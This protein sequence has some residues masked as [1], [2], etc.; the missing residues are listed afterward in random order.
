MMSLRMLLIVL[1]VF[2]FGSCLPV[3]SKPIENTPE[4]LAWEAWIMVPPTQNKTRKIT[5]KSIF[6]LPNKTT[7]PQIN[8]PPGHVVEN[9]KCIPTVQ[10]DKHMILL[11]NLAIL[12]NNTSQESNPDYD[13]D[14][15]DQYKLIA[16]T[17][18]NVPETS[19]HAPDDGDG[20]LKIDLLDP[21]S[22]RDDNVHINDFSSEEDEL[23]PKPFRAEAS[24]STP[25]TTTTTEVTSSNGIP[26]FVNEPAAGSTTNSSASSTTTAQPAT[27][28]PRIYTEPSTTAATTTAISNS[29]SA[30][31]SSPSTTL[32][33]GLSSTVQPSSILPS[34]F[35]AVPASSSVPLINSSPSHEDLGFS[36]NHADSGEDYSY[37]EEEQTRPTTVED[38]ESTEPV[39][40]PDYTSPDVH[41]E[42]EDESFRV[43]ATH[44]STT[45]VEEA[46]NNPAVADS[47]SN[48]EEQKT[49]SFPVSDTHSTMTSLYSVT[50]PITTLTPVLPTKSTFFPS[51]LETVKSTHNSNTDFSDTTIRF[52]D[53]SSH[54]TDNSENNDRFVYHHLGSVQSSK[55]PDRSDPT[56][57]DVQEQLRMINKIV[58]ENKKRSETSSQVRFPSN[59]FIQTDNVR[60]D[61]VRFPESTASQQITPTMPTRLFTAETKVLP[62]LRQP[63]LL[64]P[65]SSLSS[66]P[67]PPTTMTTE[68]QNPKPFWWLP[69]SWEVDRDGDKP[70][71]LRFWS[72]ASPTSPTGTMSS[73]ATTGFRENS[74]RPTDNLYREISAQDF[75]KVLGARNNRHHNTNEFT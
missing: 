62:I 35:D 38:D 61:F 66:F 74:R 15:E 2:D 63:T 25:A 31:I 39:T 30:P 8:C 72:R 64:T 13:Y 10:I 68:R 57:Q 14:Y 34:S 27:T 12:L 28:T 23:D 45:T 40:S 17:T 53:D 24:S 56:P 41:E 4:H 48:Y 55:R 3:T 73:T 52:Q 33:E 70:L 36:N 44:Q 5:P 60:A 69:S 7:S 47:F 1:S 75:Y 50:K 58:E 71:L 11:N 18:N 49:S 29:P 21:G 16:E 65:T 20:P 46:Q 19:N 42:L 51:N 32:L 26:E 6:I 67:N 54:F 59:T 43:H 22:I 37:L 9:S